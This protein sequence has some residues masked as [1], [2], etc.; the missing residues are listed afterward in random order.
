MHTYCNTYVFFSSFHTWV[1]SHLISTLTSL[2]H[3]ILLCLPSP[4]QGHDL[5][6]IFNTHECVF[7]SDCLISQT[8][9][10]MSI[11]WR[12]SKSSR[13]KY[14]LV[15]PSYSQFTSLLVFS[16]GLKN[17]YSSITVLQWISKFECVT[18]T[19]RRLRLV[20]R[21]RHLHPLQTHGS[22]TQWA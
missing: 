4:S 19:L 8:R 17:Y 10:H 21:I 13:P 12:Y 3:Q 2:H 22:K 16:I 18:G 7:R 14:H 11:F 6:F 1:M 9:F 20:F 15:H 5:I